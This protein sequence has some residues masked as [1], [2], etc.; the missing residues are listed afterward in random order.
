MKNDLPGI[1]LQDP[2][3]LNSAPIITTYK[4]RLRGIYCSKSLFS[5]SFQGSEY[6]R[7]RKDFL[8]IINPVIFKSSWGCS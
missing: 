2:G 7:W 3:G 1:R 4:Y 6:I 8:L 5:Y